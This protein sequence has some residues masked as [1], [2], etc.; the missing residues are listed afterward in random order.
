[1]EEEAK[2]I[3]TQNLEPL[4]YLWLMLKVKVA[5]K[6]L[7]NIAEL[8]ATQAEESKL[9]NDQGGGILINIQG[10]QDWVP[11]RPKA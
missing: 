6:N 4:L 3:Q 11:K 7:R 9:G 10:F 5:A 8:S 1:M 2:T